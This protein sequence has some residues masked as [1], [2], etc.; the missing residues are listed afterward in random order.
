M[1]DED[2]V[3][4]FP[5]VSHKLAAPK[6]LS[7]FEKE[8][9][10]AEEKRKRAEEENAA[11]LKDFEASFG[12][13]EGDDRYDGF[14]RFNGP[15]SG[16]RGAGLGQRDFGGPPGRYGGP[17]STSRSGPGSLGPIPGPPPPSLKRKRALDE[18][19]E[20]QEARKESE[21][22]QKEYGRSSSG[23]GEQH[24]S[25]NEDDNV[26]TAPR[27]TVQL[28]SLPP[29][30][31]EKDV[32]AL[33][34]DYLAV[35]EVTFQP[36]SLGSGGRKTKTAI[37]T[38]S[39][40]T[41][42]SQIDTATSALKDKYLGT[43]FYLSISRHLSST[44]LLPTLSSVPTG[45]ST[46]PFGAQKPNRDQPRGGY[47]MRNAPP[48]S[49]FAPPESYDTPARQTAYKNA[50]IT[51]QP[52]LDIGTIRAIHTL[53]DRLLSEPDPDC[54]LQ[55]EALLM[56][57]PEVRR[58][59]RFSFLYDSRSPASV[60]YRF[61]LWSDDDPFDAIQERKRLAKGPERIHD[62]III[63]WVA[64]S[65][66][67][68]FADLSALGDVIDH[69]N[70]E[71]SEEDSDDAEERQFN[72]SR[73]EGEGSNQVSDRKHLTP[74]Q[75]AKFAWLLSR[76]P[77]NH[78]ILRKGN[79]APITS[80]A[81]NHA[82]AGAEEI[83]DMMVLNVEKPFTGTQCARFDQD[84][85]LE[86]D[87][88]EEPDQDLPTIGFASGQ[89]NG[90]KRD[91]E[92]PSAAKI[93]ALYLINDILHNAST[94]GVRNAWKYRQ[95]FE[96]A[97]RHQKTF[98]HLGQLDKELGWGRIKADK[99]RRQIGV[100][101]DIWESGS[102]FATEV[103]EILKKNFYDQSTGETES[104]AKKQEDT[105]E[106]DN[107]K[108]RFKRVEANGLAAN[109]A[110]PAPV[111]ADQ[112]EATQGDQDVDG[113]AMHDVDGA[114]MD[115]IDGMPMDDLD[116][117]PMDAEMDGAPMDDGI[118]N[119]TPAKAPTEGPLV[120]A[121]MSETPVNA[122]NSAPTADEPTGK[123]GFTIKTSSASSA[124]EPLR[125]RKLAEDMFADDS[126]EE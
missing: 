79:I 50:T 66:E 102:I 40:E 68:P 98:E 80:F 103:F 47:S 13:D 105:P 117:E 2:D 28:S 106:A 30:T 39:S 120:D 125:R 65:E 78:A 93:V 70:Y 3:R 25:A 86:E 107:S 72:T 21:A 69:P 43:G 48:P 73:R 91:G 74:L 6:K 94:A 24:S 51:V 92:D 8:R 38:L 64:P 113:A 49:D 33:M 88:D 87:D 22:L 27:P 121:P 29:S 1:A 110:S 85:R 63:D 108:D 35:H 16:P 96:N 54:A 119:E 97:F 20:A 37:A 42:T 95:L 114:P 5:D 10:A 89:D 17:T 19:R 101:F 115:G 44:S 14:P 123:A 12:G 57:Q 99:W 83:V 112:D 18:M 46:E 116:G 124:A 11:A 90:E 36:Q 109:S 4:E 23:M 45:V 75:V 56:Q 84:G 60:Y 34:G 126:D 61:L 55:I 32:K 76:L 81:I 122:S 58:D 71:S 118:S 104:K 100:L 82:G 7:A 59:E 15:P 31:T 53:V 62:D 52:P 67:V 77:S 26:D 9:I 41:S 111:P